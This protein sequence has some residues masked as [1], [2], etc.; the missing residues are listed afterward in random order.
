MPLRAKLSLSLR[1][2]APLQ[3]QLQA[4]NLASPEQDAQLRA[5]ARR[6]AQPGRRRLSTST[7]PNW[8]PI[9]LAN[10]I[11]DPRRLLP[12]TQLDHSLLPLTAS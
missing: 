4:L 11:D 2:Y 9:A 10:G 5:R 7:R 8:R 12:G 6:H 1:E 3:D